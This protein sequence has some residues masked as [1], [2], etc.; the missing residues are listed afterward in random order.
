M[1]DAMNTRT[2]AALLVLAVSFWGCDS[3]VRN[4]TVTTTKGLMSPPPPATTIASISPASAKAGSPD[5][6][7]TINGSNF[8]GGHRYSEAHWT[9][10]VV[11]A[12]CCN[13]S[14]KT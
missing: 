13:T 10:S 14:L 9:T 4:T 7:V 5:I 3:P 1:E 12:Q 2:F 6:V 11:D 8:S